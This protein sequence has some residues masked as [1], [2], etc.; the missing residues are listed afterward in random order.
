[1]HVIHSIVILGGDRRQN[2]LAGMF[3]ESGFAVSCY[4][5]P[6]YPN[7]DIALSDGL[8]RAD[9]VVLPMP[10]FDSVKNIRSA[11]ASLPLQTV[12]DAVRP[13]AVI[14]GGKLAP[15]QPLLSAYQIRC[16]DYAEDE[17][18]AVFNAIPS[19]EGAIRIAME[20]TDCT[21]WNSHVLV[22][23]FGRIGKALAG[24][25]H[26]LGADVAVSAR[27]P[28]DLAWIRCL[29]YR[30][31]QT[32]IYTA[33]LSQYDCIF[34]TVPAPVLFPDHLRDI[35]PDACIID[36]ASSPGGLDPSCSKD[37]R[38]I[39]ALALPGRVA[40]KT[41]AVFI[42]DSILRNLTEPGGLLP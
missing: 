35:R 20:H 3:A 19:A 21:L 31:E 37:G 38:Y 7:P 34:N 32:G 12:L 11:D 29:G 41:A 15:G 28:A 13:D 16:F 10:A 8:S 1:M 17:S 2:Y 4:Q 22:I 33:G 9:L 26:A 25:L 14:A 18:L 23:G 39:P 40:P 27:K 5:V 42:R 6:G 36:L 24:R 30:A